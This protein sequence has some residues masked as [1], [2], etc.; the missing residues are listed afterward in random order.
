MKPII[1][2]L[3]FLS[4]LSSC[5]SFESKAEI[6]E[7]LEVEVPSCYTEIENPEFEDSNALSVTELKLEQDCIQDFMDDISEQSPKAYCGTTNWSEF[8]MVFCTRDNSARMTFNT[9]SGVLH[10]EKLK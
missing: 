2:N 9:I 1:A 4:I 6:E 3:I 8:T 7:L 5:S 10:Y